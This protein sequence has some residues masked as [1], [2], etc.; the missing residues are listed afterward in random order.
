MTGLSNRGALLAS[1]TTP[2]EA[3]FRAFTALGYTA[4]A[5][6]ASIWPACVATDQ[7][8][9]TRNDCTGGSPGVM[10]RGGDQLAVSHCCLGDDDRL[11]G[12][13]AIRGRESA[14]ETGLLRLP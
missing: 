14:G 6:V 3:M 2:S 5:A 12:S 4:A 8:N 11:G 1:L 9:S 10:E 7:E 13:D